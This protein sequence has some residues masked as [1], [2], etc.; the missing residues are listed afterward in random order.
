VHPFHTRRTRINAERTGAGQTSGVTYQWNDNIVEVVN[1]AAFP[2]TTALLPTWNLIGQGAADN[3]VV[4]ERI[5]LAGT[6][7]VMVTAE[8]DSFEITCT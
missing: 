4:K 5:D 7:M 1:D 3:F 6:R 8:Y 2:I